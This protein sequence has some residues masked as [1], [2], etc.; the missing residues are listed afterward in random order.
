MPE[1]I[2]EGRGADVGLGC[3]SAPIVRPGPGK[4][5]ELLADLE[6]R[7]PISQ[8]NHTLL[9]PEEKVKGDVR[10]Q[11]VDSKTLQDIKVSG[12]LDSDHHVAGREGCGRVTTNSGLSRFGCERR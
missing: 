3:V 1:A 12:L 4:L 11:R 5:P 2:L 8:S 7:F 10:T 9:A 6:Q